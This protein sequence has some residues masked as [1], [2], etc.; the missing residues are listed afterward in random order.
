MKPLQI[1]ERHIHSPY[2]IFIKGGVRHSDREVMAM[3]GIE[4]FKEARSPKF[5]NRFM[6]ITDDGEWLHIAD[7]WFY[8]LWHSTTV[9]NR[10]AEI[11]KEHD[12]FTCSVGDIDHSFNFQY[13]SS[14]SLV[15]NYVVEDPDHNGGHV[16]EDF[17][18]PL[19]AEF[20]ALTQTCELVK[21]LSIAQSLGIRVD[22]QEAAV[23]TFSRRHTGL[24]SLLLNRALG[25]WLFRRKSETQQSKT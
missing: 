23:R 4:G 7:D 5:S 1:I 19:P 8:S 10:I 25:N 22:H 21:V 9:R 14:G 12:I 11:A 15:R 16:T 17:G 20:E 2:F 18:V 6:H 13:Y 24:G 3:L